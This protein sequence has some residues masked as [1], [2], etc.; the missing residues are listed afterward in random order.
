MVERTHE[1]EPVDGKV[2]YRNSAHNST[3]LRNDAVDAAALG[4]QGLAVAAPSNCQ[5]RLSQAVQAGNFKATQ[6]SSAYAASTIHTVKGDSSGKQ[7][8]N[9]MNAKRDGM[10]PLLLQQDPGATHTYSTH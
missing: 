1:V 10:S 6:E 8:T 7:R 9:H 5:A 4:C 3:F 2:F